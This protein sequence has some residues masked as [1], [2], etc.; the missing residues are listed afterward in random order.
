MIPKYSSTTRVTIRA[1]SKLSVMGVP[2]RHWI[3]GDITMP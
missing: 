1:T 2:I 3:K